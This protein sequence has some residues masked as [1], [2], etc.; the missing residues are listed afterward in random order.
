M[1]YVV[2]VLRQIHG[3]GSVGTIYVVGALLE[4]CGLCSVG[5]MLSG[6]CRKSVV[7][8]LN[9]ICGCILY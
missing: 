1:K 5:N 6:F 3:W 4:I 2:V 9:G 7:D 8:I